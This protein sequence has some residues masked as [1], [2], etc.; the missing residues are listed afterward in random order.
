[1]RRSALPVS[2]LAMIAA[3]TAQAQATPDQASSS[4][5]ALDEI[6][7]TAQKRSQ[8]LRDVPLS[9]S[10]TSGEELRAVT[11]SGDDIRVLSGRIPNLNAESTFGRVYPRFYIRG[12]GNSDF[13]LNASQ[14]VAMYYDEVVLENSVLKGMPAFDLERIEVLRGPQGSL[15]GKNATAG[16]IHLVSRKPTQAT[17]GYG[18]ISY[19]RFNSYN[20]EAALGGAVAQDTLSARVSVLYQHRDPWVKNI[21]T[22]NKLDGYDDLAFRAQL[23][24]TPTAKFDALLQVYGRSLDGSSTLFN[25]QGVDAQYGALPFNKYNIALESD[26]QSDQTVHERGVTLNAAYDLGGAKLTSISAYVDGDMFSVGDIDGS[27]RPA[28]INTTKVDKLQ[29]FTQEVRLASDNNG[30]LSW[31]I[32]GHYFQ[33]WLRYANLTANNT[34]Q[35]ADGQPGFGAYQKARQQS[36]SAAVF[37][38]FTY[39]VTDALKMTGGLR[40]T[41]D[42][43]D[44]SQ[45]SSS[46]T[47]KASDLTAVPNFT[48]DPFYRAGGRGPGPWFLPRYSAEG[49][50]WNKLTWDGS[51]A[52]R[53]SDAVN[54]YGRVARGYHAGVITGQAMFDPL[55]K[56]GPETVTSYEAGAKTQ[57]LDR[58][59]TANLSVFKYVYDDMQLVAYNRTGNGVD[60][61]SLINAKGGEGQGFEFEGTLIVTPE[62][63]V[64]ANLGYVDTKISGPTLIADPR[65][66]GAQLD[67][68]GQPFPFAA[69]WTGS[70]S[71]EYVHALG[72]GDAV[73]LATDWSYR[74]DENFSLTSG[75]QPNLRGEG[76]WEGGA[77]AGYRFRQSEISVWAR[78]ITDVSQLTSAVTVNGYAGVFT[79]PRTYGVQLSTRF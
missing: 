45:D 40:Y 1:M 50:K 61:I 29:Q 35:T 76:Y 32:G 71:A 79:N 27:P 7:V 26:H 10:A 14:P 72:A 43:V 8:N 60:R 34:F 3:S 48:T 9:V 22:G 65:T 13:T 30:P 37:G 67:I 16:A 70:V 56:A 42:K 73:F 11:A 55:Q 20:L 52:Y 66:A 49:G 23:L 69:K 62:L 41:A 2:L 59:L 28:L 77:R 63:R 64:S 36:R 78:N 6:V 51:L 33:E 38:Q 5:Q 25:G 75:V 17:E 47:P 39:D 21:V 44:F 58:R 31:Q 4:V 57:W 19:G 18:R 74:G 24:W 15:W 53:L 54:L 68:T 12:L 46:F